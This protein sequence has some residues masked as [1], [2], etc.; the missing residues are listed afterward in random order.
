M[1]FED[2]FIEGTNVLKNKLGIT[3]LDLLINVEGSI[4][5]EKLADFINLN[6]E[7]SPTSGYLCFIH[8]YLFDSIYDF[9]GKYRGV[10]IFKQTEFLDYSLI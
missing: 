9:A 1:K 6:C 8:K 5:L 3:D 10:N 7:F 2:Y 4:V